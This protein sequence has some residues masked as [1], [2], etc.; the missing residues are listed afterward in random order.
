MN[1]I[2]FVYELIKGANAGGSFVEYYYDDPTV[3]G[4]EETGSPKI[5]YATGFPGPNTDQMVVVGSGI[6]VADD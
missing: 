6:F 3:E 5:G 4:D 1:G 2:R